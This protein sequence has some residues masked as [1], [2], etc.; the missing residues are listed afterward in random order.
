MKKQCLIFAVI[1][2]SFI[3][4][5]AQTNLA[6]AEF[7]GI[8]ISEEETLVLTERLRTELFQT[9]QFKIIERE[10]VNTILDEQGFQQSGCVSDECIVE[11]GRIVGVEQIVG[12]SISKIAE[13]YSVTAKIVSVE[14]GEVLQIA[15]YDCECPIDNLLRSGMRIVA[16]KLTG[17]DIVESQPVTATEPKPQST[18]AQAADLK[19]PAT[20]QVSERLSMF[21]FQLSIFPSVQLVPSEFAVYGIRVNLFHG[22]NRLINGLDVGI[23]NDVETKMRGLQA[24][25]INRSDYVW[26]LQTGVV[27]FS[28]ESRFGQISVL[29]RSKTVIGTQIG[30]VNITETLAGAQVGLINIVHKTRG[31]KFMPLI[32]IGF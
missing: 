13:M 29:N 7:R 8:G 19:T 23:I 21:P 3:I 25:I 12:G 20:K 16:E 9:K 27:C 1:L 32:N 31:P 10:M 28:R 15:T 14:T 6:V 17:R 26:G 2:F 4:S 18:A 30:V 11:I 5:F 24:G 22:R